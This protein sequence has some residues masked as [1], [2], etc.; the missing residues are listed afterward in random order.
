MKICIPTMGNQGLDEYVGEHFGR[1][2]TFTMIDS[3]TDEVKV[4]PNTSE[5]MGGTGLPAEIL[6]KQG[7]DVMIC[8]GLGR[9]AIDIFEQFGIN[10]YIGAYG[11]VRDAMEMW[12]TN[13]L[14][15]ATDENACAQHAFRKVEHEG[16]GGH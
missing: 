5:H 3:E 1:V 9:R 12:K 7:I 15:Q 10:V 6:A 8:S 11:R 16:C 2:P 4:V 14:Q 13:K